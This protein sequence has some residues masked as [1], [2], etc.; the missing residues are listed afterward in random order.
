MVRKASQYS[1]RSG[2]ESHRL[3]L[4]AAGEGGRA[5]LLPACAAPDEASR[6]SCLGQDLMVQRVLIIPAEKVIQTRQ[7]D[8]EAKQQVTR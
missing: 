1:T 4:P 6:A 3:A 7:Q 8:Q 2:G 5:H